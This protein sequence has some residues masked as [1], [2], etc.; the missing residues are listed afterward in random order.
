MSVSVVLVSIASG[1][2]EDCSKRSMSRGLFHNLQ[3]VRRLMKS[4]SDIYMYI[5]YKIPYKILKIDVN[6]T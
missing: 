5:N 1:D 6:R 2:C 4:G 3:A